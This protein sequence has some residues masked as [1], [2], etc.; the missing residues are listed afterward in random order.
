[1]S[2]IATSEAFP[3]SSP[4]RPSCLTTSPKEIVACAPCEPLSAS[5]LRSWAFDANDTFISS[6]LRIGSGPLDWGPF[7]ANCSCRLCCPQ[8]R[9]CQQVPA[10][11]LVRRKDSVETAMYFSSP[12]GA[13]SHRD[14]LS[15]IPGLQIGDGHIKSIL[16]ACAW[17]LKWEYPGASIGRS[18]KEACRALQYFVLACYSAMHC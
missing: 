4:S 15:P 7:F 12:I 18:R 3:R 10:A 11:Q 13:H 1:M 5:D 9:T 14:E 2:E 6:N 17:E 16:R 8:V